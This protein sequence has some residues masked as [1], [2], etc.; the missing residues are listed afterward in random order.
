MQHITLNE[1][2][3]NLPTLFEQVSQQHEIIEVSQNAEQAV[4]LIASQ[5]YRSLIETLYLLQSQTN[6]DWLNQGIAQH[7]QGRVREID[8]TAYSN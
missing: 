4:I 1:L 8:V 2:Q 5:E 3:A 7:R 6:A